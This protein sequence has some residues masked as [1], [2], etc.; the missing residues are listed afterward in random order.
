MLEQLV[1]QNQHKYIIATVATSTTTATYTTHTY[2]STTPIA[3]TT[4]TITITTALGA[5]EADAT[6]HELTIGSGRTP[7]IRRIDVH[8]TRATLYLGQVC[9]R[10]RGEVGASVIK[11][12]GYFACSRSHLQHVESSSS[13]LQHTQCSNSHKHTNH[14]KTRSHHTRIHYTRAPQWQ[15]KAA[16]MHPL[17]A[18]DNES[19]NHT[20]TVVGVLSLL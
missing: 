2:V 16:T 1:S 15:T 10:T 6:T 11:P 18:Q 13:D 5:N 19:Q 20:V 12:C 7:V 3:T 14:K 17:A 9:G 4:T 8:G